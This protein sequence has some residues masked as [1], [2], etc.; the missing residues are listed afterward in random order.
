MISTSLH[1]TFQVITY[2]VLAIIFC[3]IGFM[4]LLGSFLPGFLAD[5]NDFIDRYGVWVY[6]NGGHY[7][8]GEEYYTKVRDTCIFSQSSIN[9]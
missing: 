1:D 2:M 9:W 7:T 5:P 3:V 6:Y 8:K 4:G